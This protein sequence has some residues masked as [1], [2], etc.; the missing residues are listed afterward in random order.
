MC[1]LVALNTVNHY[2]SNSLLFQS[3]IKIKFLNHTELFFE[4]KDKLLIEGSIDGSHREA[5]EC[6]N[7]VEVLLV[8]NKFDKNLR[9]EYFL[10]NRHPL[11]LTLFSCQIHQRNTFILL[12][13]RLKI[14]QQTT[15]N[16]NLINYDYF[17]FY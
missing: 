17:I 16:F 13:Y 6:L 14:K 5:K 7:E 10:V 2:L 15:V 8:L 11:H 1:F 3:F 9:T 12:L 4:F